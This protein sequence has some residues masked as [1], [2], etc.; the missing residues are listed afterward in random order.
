VGRY[1]WVD[2][3]DYDADLSV[4]DLLLMQEGRV[5]RD[6]SCRLF[7]GGSE[8]LVVVVCPSRY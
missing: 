8:K 6:E 5:E 7:L 1:D 2:I 4:P 3:Y